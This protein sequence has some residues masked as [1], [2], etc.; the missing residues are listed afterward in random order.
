M[1]KSIA[2][3]DRIHANVDRESSP[4]WL[5]LGVIDRYGYARI[6]IDSRQRAAHRVS[7]EEFVGPVADGLEIDHLC[8]N[9]ACVNPSHLEAVTHAENMARAFQPK[10]RC[11]KGHELSGSNLVARSDGRHGNC[12]TCVNERAR[13]YKRRQREARKVLPRS[14]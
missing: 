2:I 1:P 5:W 14:A 12:R 10:Q 8:R 4:C 7:Y 13:E 6:K 3:R 9:R 11:P